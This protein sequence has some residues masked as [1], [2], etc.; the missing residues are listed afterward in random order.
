MTTVSLAAGAFLELFRYQSR[1]PDFFTDSAN[2][3]GSGTN[4]Y[5]LYH[6]YYGYTYAAVFSMLSIS[7]I[8]AWIGIGVNFDYFF[9]MVFAFFFFPW[10]HAAGAVMIAL[11]YDNAYTVSQDTSSSYQATALA[12]MTTIQNEVTGMMAI[13]VGRQLEEKTNQDN[14]I[15]AHYNGLSDE[16]RDWWRENDMVHRWIL[17]NGIPI[18]HLMAKGGEGEGKKNNRKE[19]DM[20]DKKD[21][22]KVD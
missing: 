13:E 4:W 9:A 8:L 7:H 1:T 21:M 5:K 11:A 2:V 18:W 22:D 6:Q 16:D 20:K 12:L 19:M 3:A 10:I 14:W 17:D 15:F